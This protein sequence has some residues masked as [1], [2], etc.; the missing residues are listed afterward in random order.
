MK[1]LLLISL[2]FGSYDYH[3]AH[4]VEDQNDCAEED[5]HING[6]GEIVNGHIHIVEDDQKT[7]NDASGLVGSAGR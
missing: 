2:V 4:G 3:V 5:F 7:G 1:L 6:R